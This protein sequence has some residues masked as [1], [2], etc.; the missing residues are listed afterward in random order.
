M[1]ALNKVFL[2]GNL[3]RD[4]ELR[5]IPGGTAVTTFGLAVSH[6][7]KTQAGDLR[8]EVCF[9]KVVVWGKQAETCSQYL[10][11]GQP[12][13]V[14][15]KLQ[16]RAWEGQD[17]KKRNTIE[18]KADRVQFLGKV[19]KGT[20]LEG[21]KADVAVQQVVNEPEESVSQ[22]EEVPF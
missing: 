17:G 9:V 8:E 13:F 16:Y 7:Y 20:S 19:Q 6:N 1:A 2:I 18:V 21:E 15:G 10:N 22:D 11:K 5:Y 14:E 3:T 4:P 12:V